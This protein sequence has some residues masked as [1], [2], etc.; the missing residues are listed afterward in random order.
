MLE[1]IQLN[2]APFWVGH[3]TLDLLFELR[4]V[5]F[6]VMYYYR[7]KVIVTLLNNGV[8]L[9]VYG[10]SWKAS[11]FA[12]HW[13]IK[14][15]PSVTGDDVLKV[16]AKSKISLN[17]MAWHKDGFTERIAN[18]M[19]NGSVVVFDTSTQLEELFVNNKDLVLFNLSNLND[20]L[21]RIK[22]LLSSPENLKD[23]KKWHEQ[24]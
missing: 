16:M 18:S 13:L 17:I 20:L 3:S 8:E 15:H 7:E 14:I 22:N 9:H 21:K 19:L 6:G 4:Y 12:K 2:D 5:F 1:N 24:G 23:F 10:D 11:Y